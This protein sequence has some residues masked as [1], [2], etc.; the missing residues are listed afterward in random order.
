MSFNDH[1]YF[2]H[3][4]RRPSLL[5]YLA[6][7]LLGAVIG[8]LIVAMLSPM[9]LRNAPEPKNGQKT[10]SPPPLAAG[11]ETPVIKIAETV[12][13]T[14][15]GISNR[16]NVSTF[17]A[18][19][20][21]EKG[22]GS[23]VVFNENG[24]IV[25]NYHVVKDADQLE[26]TLH[27]GRKVPG[28]VIGFDQR[29]D[30]AVVKINEKNLKAAAFGN[31]DSIRV[32]ELA[33]AIGNPLG[34]ELAST[35]TA[36]VISALN[37]SVDVDEQ[38][39]QLIQTDAA[40]NPGNSGGALVNSNGEVI[41]INSVKIADITVEGLNFAIPINVVKPIS[42]SIIKYGK[43][44][45]PWVGILGGDVNQYIADQYNLAVD[46]GVYVS[47][48]PSG[49]PADK[50]GM[51]PGDVIISFNKT[52]VKNF[53]DLRSFVD[54]Q[55]IGEKVQVGIMRGKERKVLT[56]TLEQLPEQ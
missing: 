44:V 7:A 42:E 31:S 24:Y 33:V 26:V 48:I 12:S 55:K 20:R 27:D 50:A 47:E 39:F 49:G 34:E 19:Q 13:P 21:V 53:G 40:I 29:S 28:K 3:G 15:V 14:V 52:Q 10:P 17:F 1:D 16:V 11:T 54:K 37:R 30:L 22:A 43:V 23:G 32:G 45:R 51:K 9:L 5:S 4:D 6:A 36:G 46:T 35:V 41:G 25:T 38:R 18:H 2:H 8:G 56:L